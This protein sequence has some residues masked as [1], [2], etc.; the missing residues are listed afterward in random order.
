MPPFYR[1]GRCGSVCWSVKNRIA[2]CAARLDARPAVI[3]RRWMTWWPT[4]ELVAHRP[5]VLVMPVL[6]VD[7][8]MTA[9]IETMETPQA[10][11]I[12]A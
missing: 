5:L 4:H 9:M 2:W 8:A 10:V 6:G 12:M 1:G 3:H 11:E 7:N